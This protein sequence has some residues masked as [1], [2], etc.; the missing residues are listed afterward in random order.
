MMLVLPVDFVHEGESEKM[1][2]KFQTLS[3]I[4]N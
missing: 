3:R 1:L 4:I 2:V